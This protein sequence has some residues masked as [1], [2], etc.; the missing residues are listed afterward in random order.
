MK[1]LS[2]T[3]HPGGYYTRVKLPTGASF[4]GSEDLY[5]GFSAE[6]SG[7]GQ[8]FG[9]TTLTRMETNWEG[10]I[11]GPDGFTIQAVGIEFIPDALNVSTNLSD[12]FEL[13]TKTALVLELGD[14]RINLGPSYRWPQ[15]VGLGEMQV[16]SAS[17]TAHTDGGFLNR[18]GQRLLVEPIHLEEGAKPKIRMFTGADK[19][20]LV[21]QIYAEIWLLGEGRTPVYG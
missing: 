19:P 3:I 16:K 7:T 8:G 1:G 2:T 4:D 11:I 6:L 15:G 13:A 20:A 10:K 14:Q 12:M 5:L 9:S 21:G 18:P 17:S